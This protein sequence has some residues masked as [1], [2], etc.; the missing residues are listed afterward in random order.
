MTTNNTANIIAR[1]SWFQDLPSDA[2]QKLSESAKIESYTKN[3]FL[4]HI[5]DNTKSVYCILS[6]RIRM[7]LMS[8]QGQQYS[9]DDFVAEA[10]VGESSLISSDI[11][12]FELQFIEAGQAL[13][14][15]H[16]IVNEVGKEHPIIF[17]NILKDHG[18]RTRGVYEILRVMLFHSLKSRLAGRILFMLTNVGVRADGGYYLDQK[19][20]QQDLASFAHGSR[21]QV[22]KIL[23]KWDNEG[24]IIM[25][26]N[27][28]FIT[29]L[30]R[31]KQEVYKTGEDNE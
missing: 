19:L 13:S 27:R 15:N 28:Y 22:N 10:W 4:Y 20:S 25:K 18:H 6:G 2:Q 8:T 7:S 9:V 24:L 12:L 14:L 1:S 21:Q 11:Q 30:Y 29:D 5:G 16:K 31:L 3:S 26:F 17:Y 23:K